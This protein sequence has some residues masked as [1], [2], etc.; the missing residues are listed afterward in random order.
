VFGKLTELLWWVQLLDAT[1]LRNWTML[2]DVL[3]E[4]TPLDCLAGRDWDCELPR[5]ISI[6]STKAPMN[7]QGLMER[8]K[9]YICP[10]EY[11]VLV[12]FKRGDILGR[13]VVTYYIVSYD[14]I[15]TLDGREAAKVALELGATIPEKRSTGFDL[16]VT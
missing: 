5:S 13:N 11:I 14:T 7:I 2:R 15:A 6:I 9:K 16:T 8:W 1:T 3:D 10:D 4:L 12:E